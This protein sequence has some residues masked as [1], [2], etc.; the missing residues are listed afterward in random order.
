MDFSI[1][2]QA[3]EYEYIEK[4]T[5]WFWAVGIIT[6]ALA[7]VAILVGNILF[8]LVILLAGFTLSLHAARKPDIVNFE[9]NPKGVKVDATLYPFSTLESF[10]VDELNEINPKIIF[11]SE[12]PFMPVI[13]LP[14]PAET[15]PEDIRE[16]L[17]YYLEEE[18]MYEPLSHKLMEYLGF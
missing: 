15:D 3:H 10:W 18:E 14:M 17:R 5:N 6:A 1:Q 4:D 2:W 16:Y 11:K 12:K 13:I 9:I 8:A 7:L